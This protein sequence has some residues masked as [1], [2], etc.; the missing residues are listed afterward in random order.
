MSVLTPVRGLARMSTGVAALDAVLAGGFPAQ[1][2]TVVAGEPGTGKTVLALQTLFAAA[3]R[4]E[5]C[6]YF[7]TLS[8]PSIKLLRYMQL[9]DFFDQ[10]LFDERIAIHDLGSSLRGQEPEAAFDQLTHRVHE[11]E[12]ALVVIDSYKAIH[13][14]VLDPSRSRTFTYDLAVEMA[15]WGATTLLVG[16]YSVEEL[17]ILPEFAIADG[18]VR[19]GIAR[20]ELAHVRELEVRKLRGSSYAHGVHFFEIGSPGISF[21]PR[22]QVPDSGVQENDEV[23]TGRLSTGVAGIDELFRGGIP[24]HS[25]T[26]VM[27]GTGTGKTLLGLHYLVDGARK[28]EPGILFTLEETLG[29]LRSISGAYGFDLET[30]EEQGLVHLSY[31]A[32]VELSTDK[33]LDRARR[34]ADR[35]GAK[36]AVLDGLTTLSLGSVSERRYKELVY[37]LAKH[38]RAMGITLLA[39]MEVND[40][41]GTTK[42]SGHGLSF[43]AD[44]I[45]QLRYIEM[46]ARLER[47]VSVLKARGVNIVTELRPVTIGERGMHVGATADFQR[48]P[49]ALSG[50]PVAGP[51]SR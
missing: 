3:R 14:L 51:D 27:G 42:I 26:V 49:G 50:L 22:V 6:M 2:V 33:F 29:Q 17:A 35:F 8:E 7:T 25:M 47:A 12:P 32:P 15:G 21:Y 5:R 44:N 1:S 38:F 24:E 31:T 46:G 45:I 10:G 48:E 9:F 13:D 40:L 16:E 43:A 11:Q 28:G 23:G 18:I 30:L 4:G 41:A 20:Q 39:T 34:L 36:R 37:A 19:L